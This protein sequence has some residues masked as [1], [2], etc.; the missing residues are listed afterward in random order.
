MESLS[1]PAFSPMAFSDWD[2]TP[3]RKRCCWRLQLQAARVL[4]VVC[5]PADGPDR[6]APGRVRDSLGSDAPMGRVGAHPLALLD[7]TI[8]GTDGKGPYDYSY[9][10]RAILREPSRQKWHR[11]AEGPTRVGDVYPAI[12]WRHQF[13]CPLSCCLP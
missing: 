4:P 12:R 8:K 5:G 1:E 11:A 9:H 13:E 2:V 6:G 7:R 10:D 3:A